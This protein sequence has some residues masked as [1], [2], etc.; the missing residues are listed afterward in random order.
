M[1]DAVTSHLGWRSSPASQFVGAFVCSGSRWAEFAESLAA[2]GAS[3]VSVSVTVAEVAAVEDAL[4]AGSAEPRATLVSLEV[5]V[6]DQAGLDDALKVLDA[7]VPDDVTA[8]VELP[9]SAIDHHAC[10]RLAAGWHHLKIRTGGAS[11]ASF[12][13]EALLARIIIC[14]VQHDL[15][16]KLT[17][18]LHDAV[19][20][21][22]PVTAFEHH[23]F[24]NVIAATAGALAGNNVHTVQSLLATQDPEHLADLVRRLEPAVART[25]RRQFV[26]FGTCNIDEPLQDLVKL[27]LID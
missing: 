23:G 6:A 12:P 17:A 18:G 27:R 2:F 21:R 26:S 9:W 4:A 24:L 14:S 25:V 11:A 13:S 16:F 15:P 19:R 8:F 10:T 7:V 20:H 1:P 22:D 5:P 3:G